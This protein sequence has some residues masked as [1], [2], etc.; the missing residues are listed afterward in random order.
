MYRTFRKQ[1]DEIPSV[2]R[3]G[4]V[5]VAMACI[6]YSGV[7]AFI[8]WL[9]FEHVVGAAALAVVGLRAAVGRSGAFAERRKREA[10]S[11]FEQMLF[12]MT[13]SLQA[14]KSVENAFRTAEDDLKRMYEGSR[15][16]LLDQL[17]RLNRKVE[18]GTPTERAV[19]EFQRV[20][21]I[22]EIDD[23]ADMFCTCKR[24]GGDLVRVTRQT[25]RSVVEKM[26]M[27]RE[28]SVLI[29]GKR[30]EAKALS[31][32]PFLIVAMFRYGSPEYMEALYRGQGRLVMIAAL[33][34][35]GV[36]KFAA[37]RLTRIEG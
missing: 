28:L 32:V 2:Y 6:G 33:A 4:S 37:D 12:S 22:G 24:T 21:S 35:L 30:F 18:N 16:V 34:L 11:Q 15:T 27:E 9:F 14:G 29:A 31:V 19:Q 8:G 10:A 7:Y 36:G 26:T 23:W 25:S 17:E 1:W 3:P 20:L 13:S 5:R